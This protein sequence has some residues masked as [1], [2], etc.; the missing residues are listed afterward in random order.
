M[1]TT[2]PR[3]PR[4]D[5]AVDPMVLSADCNAVLDVIEAGKVAIIP[6][7]LTYAI[8]GHHADAVASIFA[9]KARSYSKPCGL[10]GSPTMSREVHDLPAERH[11]MVRVLKEEEGLPFSIVAPFRAAHPFIANVDPFVI[12]NASKGGTMDMVISGGPFVARLAELSLERGVAAFGSSANRSL[13]GSKY[14]LADIEPEVRRAASIAL[15]YGMSRYA[16]ALGLSSTIIDFRDFSVVRV[17]HEFARLTEAFQ[18][19][20]GIVLSRP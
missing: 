2:L 5:L 14:R 20:F 18:R 19:R 10:F 1:D 12:Q 4:T 3:S 15:D 16:T 17:G 11:E 8:I 13:E 6:T 7:C 9:A